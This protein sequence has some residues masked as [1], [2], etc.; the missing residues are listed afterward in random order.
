MNV[1]LVSQCS[2]NAL[3]ETR[4]ILDQFAERRGDRT[5][6]T[7]I[8][9]EG[10]DT[11]RKLLRKSARKNTAVACHWI[12]GRDHSELMWIVGDAGRFDA[13]GT[14]PTNTTRRDVLRQ[15]DENDWHT[16]EDIKLLAGLAALMHDL[17][18]SS[19]QFQDKLRPGA[20]PERNIYR[21]EW[22]SLRL[23]QAFVGNDDDHGW[24]SRLVSPNAADDKAWLERLERDGMDEGVC[25][26]FEMLPPLAG[27]I[28]WL[29]LTHHRLP[30]LPPND[31]SNSRWGQKVSGFR[32]DQLRN[33]PAVIGADWNELPDATERSR[34]EPYWC[35]D[36]ALPTASPKWRN[37][38]SRLARRL[39]DRSEKNS[40]NWLDDPYTLHLARLSLML[41]DHHYSSLSDPSERVKGEEGFPLY[42]NTDRTTGK[43]MQYLDEHLLG[44]CQ[45]ALTVAH[46]LPSLGDNLPRIAR[47][48]G[49][50]KRTQQGRFRW[51]DKAFDLA[52]SIRERSREQGFFGVNMASTGYGKTLANGRIMY[53]LADPR[54]GARFSVALGLRTLTLQTGQA[55]RQL[56]HLG[57]DEVAIRVGGSASRALF[58]HYQASAEESGSASCQALVPEDGHV[59]FEGNFEEHPVLNRVARE[60]DLKALL[61]GPILVSTVD[62]LMPAT[63][64]LKGG[65][66]IAPMLRLMTS[67]LVL[68]EVDDFDMKDLPALTRLVHWAGLL[69]SRVLLSSATMPPALV[70]GLY[71][72]YRE[73]RAKYQK[74]RGEPGLPVDVCCAWFDENGRQDADCADAEAFRTKHDEFVAA[75][76]ARLLKERK[77]ARRRSELVP[78]EIAERKAEAIRSELAALVLEK[79]RM[80]HQSHGVQDPHSEKRVSFGLVRMA[81]IEPLVD[82]ALAI[83][84]HGAPSGLRVHLCVYHSQYPLLM[85]SAIEH[86]LDQALDRRDP[87]AVFELSDV[88]NRLDGYPEEEHMFIVLGSPVTEVGRDHDYDWAIVEPSSMRSLIQL[89]GRIRRHRP[90]SCVS[91]NIALLDTNLKHL[92]RPGQPAFCRP[93]FEA[94]GFELN[95]HYLT[96]LLDPS[97]REVI[98]SVPRIWARGAL[99]PAD[100]LVDLEHYRL[101]KAMLHQSDAGDDP[102]PVETE[103]L[104]PRKRRQLK[105]QPAAPPLGAHSWY[106]MPRAPLIGVLQQQQPFR[107]QAGPPQV[108]LVLVPDEAEAGVVLQKIE[109]GHGERLYVDIEKS[110]H[111]RIDL[112]VSGRSGISPWGEADYL[113]ALEALAE[114]LDMSLE[115][116][117]RRFGIVRVPESEQGWSSHPA[118]GF[119]KC[120]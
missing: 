94:S 9:W 28:A 112:D 88:R 42:A 97:E 18:K 110:L 58:D 4:R 7:A 118:L 47:H 52:K 78:L 67:D 109:E 120:R 64:S 27:A 106:S 72:A 107:E 14:A 85:R 23:F 89:A 50:R 39:L 101:Q 65:R 62:H 96:S 79:A 24:L 92:E 76:K 104:S 115:G 26:P 77:R 103:K 114:E 95:S 34:I 53:A 44:V 63:E 75:R 48:K 73:G 15:R 43:V 59:Y 16:G 41:G 54:Q 29:I 98:D 86:R 102:E 117:A 17:G 91:P 30:V 38:A 55:Y 99:H 61:S 10:L 119:V 66:Q 80:L 74:N 82:V 51:Q 11:L 49:F 33:L 93:G 116:C 83:Y 87:N 2:K 25:R 1:L 81:N 37:R 40:R 19:R 45:S 20:K 56:L 32:A 69:G 6:Q 8:T 105:R 60:P 111:D 13:E 84:D 108:D 21:H 68:D 90:G 46:S 70:E 5:W 57:E 12:R 113:E 35:F 36:E 100:S 31:D 3:K 71:S 22:V